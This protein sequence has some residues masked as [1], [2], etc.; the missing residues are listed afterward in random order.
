[1]GV[2]RAVLSCLVLKLV[3]F[4]PVEMGI[5]LEKVYIA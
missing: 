1:M 2:G 5:L 4:K 3:C